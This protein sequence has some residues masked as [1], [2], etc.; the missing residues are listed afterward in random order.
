MTK[1]NPTL[2]PVTFR[3]KYLGYN[4]GETAGFQPARAGK[5]VAAGVAR[6]HDKETQ[7]KAK[8]L[9]VDNLTISDGVALEL[10]AMADQLA[11]EKTAE[12]EAE[13]ETALAEKD[14][15][16]AKLKAQLEKGKKK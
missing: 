5:L 15:E 7:D 11:Q 8:G 10:Q 2:L 4:G 12:I 1:A 9:N 14:A 16:I 13:K 3:K 6:W